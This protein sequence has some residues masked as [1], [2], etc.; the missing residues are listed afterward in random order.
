MKT[1][2]SL[3][4]ILL[5]VYCTPF[6]CAIAG[7]PNPI[8]RPDSLHE[9]YDVVVTGGRVMDPE[10]NVDSI[11]NIG[12][13][14]GRIMEISP[15]TMQG[16]RTIDATGLVVCP[17]FIDLLSYDPVEPGIWTK[18][19]DGVTTNLAL[20]G[21]TVD[22]DRWYRSVTRQR[23]P[24]NYGASFFY[25][26]A[27]LRFVVDRYA[28]I[29]PTARGK[30]LNLEEEALKNGALGLS[31]ALEYFPGV[32]SD[33][34]VPAMA[35]AAR[36]GVPVFFHARYSDMEVPGTNFDGLREIISYARLTHAS[37]HVDH[38]N[39][40][41]GTFS[42]PASLAL[43]DSARATGLD[44]TACM[45]PYTFW[46]T[47]LNSARFD[48]GWQSRFRISYGDL[49][50]GGSSERLT[51]ESFRLYRRQGKLA[52]AFAIPDE[53]NRA[54]LRASYVMIGSDAILEPGYN[55]HPRASGTFSRTIA[56]YVR[57]QRTISLMDAIAKMT[58][59]PAR[60]VEVASEAMKHKGRLQVGADADIVVF[61][62]A[63][64]RDRATV[65]HPEFT[66]EG[67]HYVLVNGQVVLDE[68][69]LHKN[70]RAGKPIRGP[71]SKLR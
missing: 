27:R 10:R 62:A 15:G 70:V 21:G 49:Q 38:I 45:Y 61:D 55:N 11:M 46:A 24:L 68:K 58:I 5:S 13:A 53:D 44:I 17:G 30:I 52:V 41:G 51:P 4:L 56:T 48:A 42:M 3:C 2:A 16:R 35:I 47:Y 67:I 64:I 54:A 8:S 32:G 9:R 1:H 36:H 29:G 6:L 31:F 71:I 66:S 26:S 7:T 28:N 43:L 19:A 60:R 22:P 33:E 34:I 50:L 14:G 40:T 59:L 23:P 18:I 57:D 63:R 39:S 20:H 65:E 25:N 69:G 12:I 37:V